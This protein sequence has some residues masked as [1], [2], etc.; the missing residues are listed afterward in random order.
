MRAQAYAGIV[1][2]ALVWLSPGRWTGASVRAEAGRVGIA[3]PPARPDARRASADGTP[4][5]GQAAPELPQVAAGRRAYVAHKC[6][7]CHMVAGQGNIRFKLDGVGARLSARDLERWLSDTAAMERALPR[8]PA[9]RMSEW[10]R[11]H[12]K[13]TDADR[14]ALVAYLASLK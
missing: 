1:V 8:M 5:D 2:C 11:S 3:V 12:K 10:L 14:A 9:V 4:P 7:T 13:I 6:A